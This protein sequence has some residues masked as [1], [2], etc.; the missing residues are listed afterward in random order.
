MCSAQPTILSIA[1]TKKN[2]YF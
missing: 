1:Q 2:L